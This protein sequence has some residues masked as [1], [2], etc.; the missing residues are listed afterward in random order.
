[1][2]KRSLL[3]LLVA[4][5]VCGAL[6]AADDPFVGQWKLNPS[7]SK[8]V[9]YM[10]VKRLG[11][12]KYVLDLGGGATET[13]VADGTDQPGNHG[14][15]VSVTV[16]GPVNW[17]VV[18]KGAHT[19]NTGI[20]TLSQDGKTLSD[21]FSSKQP[22]GSTFR[23]DYAYKRMTAGSGFAS[24]WVSTSEPKAS[25]L[26]IRSYTGGGL[27]FITPSQHATLNMRFDGKDYPHI[28]PDAPTG[29]MASGRRVS[30]RILEVSD[31]LKGQVI[32]TR[33]IRLSPGLKTLTV[34]MR[35]SSPNIPAFDRDTLVFDRE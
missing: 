21:H 17:K 3:L 2:L 29:Y 20:W 15:T 8:L 28:G 13:I 35:P 27:S 5:F 30:E 19:L 7:K 16:Q 18:V 12:N 24:T 25:E 11:A 1:M 4:F 10:K 34:T 14:L 26:Q 9:D 6:W 22:D 32:D 23:M 33:Q 31:K